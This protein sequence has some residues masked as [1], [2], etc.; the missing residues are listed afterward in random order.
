MRRGSLTRPHALCGGETG[1]C[2]PTGHGSLDALVVDGITG[3]D[4]SPLI[5]TWSLTC[6][7]VVPP[8]ESE[9]GYS[10]GWGGSDRTQVPNPDLKNPAC[11]ACSFA[12][13]P[14]P[15]D[16][17]TLG[18]SC[19]YYGLP[20]KHVLGRTVPTYPEAE[21]GPAGSGRTAYPLY[22]PTSKTNAFVKCHR[23]FLRLLVCYMATADWCNRARSFSNT[24]TNKKWRFQISPH[25]IWRR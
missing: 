21:P 2:L 5:I 19:P 8:T 18:S 22:R 11:L 10:M 23:D 17:L 14:S 25:R 24:W 6:D 4:S 13:M 15:W 12:P 9:L 7:L 16:E 3:F 1:E 20:H